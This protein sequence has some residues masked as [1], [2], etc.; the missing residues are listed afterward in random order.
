MAPLPL[1]PA[2]PPPPPPPPSPLPPSPSPPPPYPPATAVINT[3]GLTSALA[4]TA[5]GRIVLAP[6]TYNLDAELSITRS[7]VLEGAVAGYVILNAQGSSSNPRRVLNINPGPSDIVQLIG[8]KITGGY[9]TST[10]GGG[11]IVQGGT[12]AISSCTISGNTAGEHPIAFVRG[13]GVYVQ[14]G[15]VTFSSCTIT[16]NTAMSFS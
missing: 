1:P 16:G 11:V 3:A 10:F 9:T 14:G 5:V 13:G 12:V 7:V 6:G 4:N 8:L 15:T 2:L